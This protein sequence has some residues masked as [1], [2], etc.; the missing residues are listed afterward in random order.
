MRGPGDPAGAGQ[1]AGARRG[2]RGAARSQ[3]PFDRSAM[4]GY[5]VRAADVAGATRVAPKVLRL[6]GRG[7]HGRAVRGT[8]V[9]GDCAGIATARRCRAGADAV[10][11]VEDTGRPGTPDWPAPAWLDSTN[12]ASAGL[13]ARA[14]QHIRRGADIRS[15]EVVM[16]SGRYP[17]RAGWARSP[18]SGWI[19]WRTSSRSRSTATFRPATRWCARGSRCRR[20]RSTTSTRSRWGR[21][22]RG[23]AAYRIPARAGA[24]GDGGIRGARGLGRPRP[25]HRGAGARWSSVASATWWWTPS[26]CG[27][28]CSSTACSTSSRASPRCSRASAGSWC[29]ACRAT[30]R[31]ACSTPTSCW[32]PCCGCWR[33]AAARSALD[34]VASR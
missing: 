11:M 1:R 10:V 16:R 4:D 26:P 30:R 7:V 29:S 28:K 17:I 24:H 20:R 27:A 8:L 3:P 25:G 33:R 34:L 12:S 5:A 9:A 22:W 13:E 14:A 32:C 21:W 15:G 18:P 31:I 19:R 23:T 2:R 6:V